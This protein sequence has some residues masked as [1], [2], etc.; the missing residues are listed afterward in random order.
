MC[1]AAYFFPTALIPFKS[2]G[3]FSTG[4]YTPELAKTDESAD[5]GEIRKTKNL[6][7]EH[8]ILQKK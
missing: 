6:S 8:I 4:C 5:Q 3:L 7:Q 2:T 1:I